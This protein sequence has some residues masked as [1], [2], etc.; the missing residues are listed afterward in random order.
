MRW[1][2][3][4]NEV[5]EGS[6]R[7]FSFQSGVIF[8]FIY[9]CFFRGKKWKIFLPLINITPHKSFLLATPLRFRPPY[10]MFPLL[11]THCRQKILLMKLFSF[12]TLE[13]SWLGD[14]LCA[15]VREV[16][17]KLN[18]EL[19]KENIFWKNYL[20]KPCSAEVMICTFTGFLLKNFWKFKQQWTYFGTFF[21]LLD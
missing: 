4:E 7:R 21:A 8:F 14:V 17:W 6:L 13:A 1:W 3:R 12:F 16:G 2:E 18:M 20:W 15:M 11:Y 19:V 10:L 9:R 5:F